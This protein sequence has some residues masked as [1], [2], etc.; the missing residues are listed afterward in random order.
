[1][2]ELLG[3]VVGILFSLYYLVIQPETSGGIS[4]GGG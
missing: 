1:M 4:Q 3:L 2:F